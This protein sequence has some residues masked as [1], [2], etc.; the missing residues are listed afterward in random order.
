MSVF[1]CSLRW[2]ALPLGH[3]AKNS[4]GAAD[5]LS[6]Q[7]SAPNPAPM[8]PNHTR[9][10]VAHSSQRQANVDSSRSFM[11]NHHGGSGTRG[12][13]NFNRVGHARDASSIFA[14]KGR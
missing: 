1:S 5:A 2:I 7:A 6:Y 11:E 10:R 12:R 9:P 13:G 3:S 4:W 8:A 14:Y